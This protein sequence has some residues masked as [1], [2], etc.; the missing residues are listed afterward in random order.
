MKTYN[1][2]FENNGSGNTYKFKVVASSDGVLKANI[3]CILNMY[4]K[5]GG[6]RRDFSVTYNE[7]EV[8]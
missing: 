1:L 4:G 2:K 5:Q 6:D 8:S 3:S 7:E